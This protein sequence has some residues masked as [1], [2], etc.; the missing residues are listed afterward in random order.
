M[1]HRVFHIIHNLE[2]AGAQAHLVNLARERAP[3]IERQSIFAWK[4]GG[5]FEK[6]LNECGVEIYFGEGKSGS[7]LR[8]RRRL[9]EALEV[10]RPSLIHAH[11]SDSAFWAA[12]A[13]KRAKAPYFVTFQDGTRL[14]PE[15]AP[16]KKWLRMWLLRRAVAGATS[17]LAVTE[18]LKE[19][20]LRDLKSSADHTFFVPNCVSLPMI[21]EDG[22]RSSAGAAEEERPFNILLLGRYVDIKGQSQLI[23]AMPAILKTLP[24]AEAFLV[25]G[26][27][28]EDVLKERAVARGVER[29]VH[30]TGPTT[31]PQKH[32]RSADVYVSTSHYE[33]TSLALLE[34]M[35][36]RLPIVVSDVPGNRD[37]IRNG[38]TGLLY[39]LDDTDAL[40]R[41]ILR[42][43]R[44]EDESRRLAI[45]AREAVAREFGARA[46]LRRH[47]EIYGATAV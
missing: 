19:M 21:E 36:W 23:D 22:G 7:L 15:M 29:S 28:M 41:Q 24:R 30:I 37:V 42:L 26:G 12:M 1:S 32:F 18:S 45:Q 5:A 46:I 8:V 3:G 2:R 16:P 38:E 4:S 17:V 9:F 10:E 13:G 35:S 43:A 14:V 25:G 33:G 44:D 40:A 20:L 27:P 6:E 47:M 39:A 11:M 31:D 34:A